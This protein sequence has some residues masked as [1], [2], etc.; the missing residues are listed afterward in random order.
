[1]TNDPPP[2]SEAKPAPAIPVLGREELVLNGRSRHWIT[3]RV[4]AALE[5]RR[6]GVWW[7]FFIP[8]ALAAL[9]GLVGGFGYLVATGIGVWG[10]TNS[11][12]WGWP[13][14]NF[15]FWI[16]IGHAGTLISAILFLTRQRWRTSVSRAAEAMTIFAVT[17]AGIFPLFHMGRVWMAWFL[18]PLPVSEGVWQNFKSPLMWD[19]FAVS[20]YFLI[21]LL[22]W[23]LGMIPDLATLRDRCR[24]G[25]RKAFYG[26]MALGWR[27]AARQWSHYQTAYL[28]MAGLATALVVSVHSLVSFDFACSLL[29]GWHSTI[30]PPYFVAGAVFG[31]VAMVLTIMIPVRRIYRLHDLITP[32]HIDNMAKILLLTGLL[33]TYS[34][35]MEWFTAFFSGNK[36]ETDAVLF[37][38]FGPY[39][40]EHALMLVCNVLV[41]QL[42]WF[43]RFRRNTLVVMAVVL[44]VDLGMWLERFVIVV[45]AL[46]RSWLPGDWKLYFPS[47]VDVATTLG[48]VGLFLS[49]FLLFLRYLPSISISEVKCMDCVSAAGG[50]RRRGRRRV[51]SSDHP[52]P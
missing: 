36:F 25:I 47:W 24:P 1:M 34:Y 46:A 37:R 39:W 12:M 15:V 5:N 23:Y 20:I 41:P 49:L 33:V 21:S 7:L 27:G 50:F 19:V 51:R 4:C 9:I 43:K 10:N 8:S 22:F 35:A 42:F 2:P 14:V 45:P 48:A 26:V 44:C 52:D 40:R 32:K 3:E 18:V 11:V 31:G 17:C 30:F 16:G 28:L 6:P 13:I 38:S 29:P